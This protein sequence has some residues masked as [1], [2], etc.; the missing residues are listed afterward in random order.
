MKIPLVSR[1]IISE[2]FSRVPVDLLGPLTSLGMDHKYIL[3]VIDCANRLSEVVP[4]KN[5]NTECCRSLSDYF[6]LS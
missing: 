6:L 4:L 5:I 3:T 1:P 2:P